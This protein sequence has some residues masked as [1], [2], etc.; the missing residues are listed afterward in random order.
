MVMQQSTVKRK[1]QRFFVGNGEVG[2][3]GWDPHI[4]NYSKTKLIVIPNCAYILSLGVSYN[5]DLAMY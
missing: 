2:S 5:H 1:V 3:Y 4:R